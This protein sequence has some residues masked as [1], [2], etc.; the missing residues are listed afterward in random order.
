MLRKNFLNLLFI[1]VLVLIPGFIFGAGQ[2]EHSETGKGGQVE[3]SINQFQVELTQI[4]PELA[5]E[6]SAANS[7]VNVTVER[8]GGDNYWQV[9]KSLVASNELHDVY[10]LF[11]WSFVEEY[12]SAGLTLDLTGQPVLNNITPAF[13]DAVTYDGHIH[14]IPFTF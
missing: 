14:A 10:G 9:L 2:S 3:V 11:G 6:Y 5:Q 1:S 13:L 12:A 4:L 7:K 8:A